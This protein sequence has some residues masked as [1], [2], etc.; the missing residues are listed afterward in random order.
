MNK[1]NIC[2]PQVAINK[3]TALATRGSRESSGSVARLLRA[4]TQ[5]GSPSERNAGISAD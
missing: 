2:G 5:A 1:I 3:L 4:G